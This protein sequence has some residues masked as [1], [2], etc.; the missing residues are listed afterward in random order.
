MVVM[1]TDAYSRWRK[2]E[3][4]ATAALM[5]ILSSHHS[6]PDISINSNEGD[7]R[8]SVLFV[9]RR[10]LLAPV[11]PLAHVLCS[12]TGLLGTACSSGVSAAG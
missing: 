4:G 10:S 11:P 7:W 8:P 5:K 3:I 12:W 1:E 6:F 2:D 9:S